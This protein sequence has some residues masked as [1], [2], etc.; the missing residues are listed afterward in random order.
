MKFK[1]TK[2]G[3]LS[4]Q[5]YDGNID[6]S[7][8]GLT[9]LKGAPKIVQGEFN[10]SN[11][12]LISLKGAPEIVRGNFICSYNFLKSL[13]GAPREVNGYF[14]CHDNNLKTLKGAPKKV[15]KFFDCSGN[16][17]KSLEGIPK[18]IGGPCFCYKQL[19]NILDNMSEGIK[20]NFNINDNPSKYLCLEFK[21]RK[22]N[23]Y[24][25]ELEIKFRLLEQIFISSHFDNKTKRKFFIE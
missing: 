18:I 5:H 24:L 16:H 9:S 4:G 3:D 21:I 25:S 15:G 12:K 1:D 17:L 22:E 8:L 14:D 6:V 13:E 23:P 7:F 20:K 2:Y 19:A 11:N 10:C